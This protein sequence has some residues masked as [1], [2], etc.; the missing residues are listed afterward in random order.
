[1]VARGMGGHC[2]MPY[3]LNPSP[4]GLI[5][6]LA[7]GDPFMGICEVALYTIPLVIVGM[8]FLKVSRRLVLSS[9]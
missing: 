8:I 9:K 7:T 2:L 1:M 3:F 5:T 4:F 6:R